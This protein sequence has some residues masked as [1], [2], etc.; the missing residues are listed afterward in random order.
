MM[1]E[2]I[3][4]CYCNFVRLFH[5]IVRLAYIMTITA[6][7][8]KNNLGHYLDLAATEEIL[9]KKNGRLV[10]RLSSP[11]PNRVERMQALFGILPSTVTIDEAR[12]IRGEE[13][14]GLS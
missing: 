9:I 2:Q 12:S 5:Y 8:L 6:T 14:W 10:A 1:D 7:E 4:Q 11:E 13:K 3:E